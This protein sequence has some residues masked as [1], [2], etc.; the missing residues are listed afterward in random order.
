MIEA[1]T[2]DYDLVQSS[3]ATIDGSRIV[4]TLYADGGSTNIS[5]PVSE[6]PRLIAAIAS[7]ASMARQAQRGK[8]SLA[9]KAHRLEAWFEDRDTLLAIALAGGTELLFQADSQVFL[10][11]VSDCAKKMEY[12]T[13]PA[14]EPLQ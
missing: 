1:L 8:R 12:C 10:N 14:T 3:S 7:G 11:F 2:I 5:L 9:I 13:T 4:F 6:V